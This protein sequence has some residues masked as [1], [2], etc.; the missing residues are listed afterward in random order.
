MNSATSPGAAERPKTALEMGIMHGSPPPADCRI[1]HENWDRAPFNRWSFQH[2]RE[3][4]PTVPVRRGGGPVREFERAE[5]ELGALGFETADGRG[6]TLSG[7]LDETYTDGFIV[8]HRGAVVFERYFNDMAADTPHLS[9]SVGKSIAGTVAG[10]LIGRG[11]LDPHAPVEEHVPELAACGYRGATLAQIMDMRSGVKFS[12]VY[13]DPQS[14][15]GKVDIASG[16]KPRRNA[17]DP[18]HMFEVILGLTQDRDHGGRFEYRSIETD[19]M[20]FCMERVTGKRLAELVGTRTL[21]QARSGGRRLLHRRSGRLC[22]RRW[23]LQRHAARL[24]PLRPDASGPRRGRRRSDRAAGLGR[25][26]QPGRPVGVRRTLHGCAAQRRL[27]PAVLGRGC[28]YPAYM[29]RG[30]FGQLIHIDPDNDMV[31][32][33]LS[34]WPDFQ[35]TEFGVNTLRAI[36]AIARE[37]NGGPRRQP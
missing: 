13:T 3:I 23:R 10:I 21:V 18:G 25:G 31:T 6:V 34:T 24:C 28:E 4:L 12:E 36:H 37:L 27:R 35:N 7:F 20:A 1:T 9:Q 5:E 15:I 30:V 17:S 26:V 11:T 29:A 16:W 32:V 8:L 22:A 2:V 19:V 14:D 33:K